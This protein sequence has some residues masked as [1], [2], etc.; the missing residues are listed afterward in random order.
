VKSLCAGYSLRLGQ[1]VDGTH[2]RARREVYEQLK[3]KAS[4]SVLNK[5]ISVLD[6]SVRARKA[7]QMLNIQTLGDLAMR[8]EAELMGVKNFGATSL[9][10]VKER[11]GEHGRARGR[12]GRRLLLGDAA[13]GHDGEYFGAP[14]VRPEHP[15]SPAGV[16]GGSAGPPRYRPCTRAPTS[17]GRGG[18]ARSVRFASQDGPDAVEADQVGVR[19]L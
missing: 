7:L 14:P 11:L 4:E 17:L 19:A 1:G 18:F 2:N 12:C 10:E 8:T 16:P 15:G 13:C 5:P 6:L 3:G 9:T